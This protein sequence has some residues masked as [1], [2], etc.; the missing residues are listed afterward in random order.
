MSTI[1]TID[2]MQIYYKD[3]GRGQ[4]VVFS[5]GW[6]P[7]SA[8]SWG[9]SELFLAASGIAGIAHGRSSQ[10]RAPTRRDHAGGHDF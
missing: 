5:H 8:A 3:R 2:G 1:T 9:G 7:L 6:R 10:W 4:P